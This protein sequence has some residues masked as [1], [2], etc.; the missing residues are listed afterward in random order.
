MSLLLGERSIEHVLWGLGDSLPLKIF[1]E[2]HLLII[3][4]ENI[5]EM[6]NEHFFNGDICIVAATIFIEDLCDSVLS[7]SGK[8]DVVKKKKRNSPLH[9]TTKASYIFVSSIVH[10]YKPHC[11]CKLLDL[12]DESYQY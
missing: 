10:L 8:N 3:A 9:Q 2:P 12:F 4:H 11:L 6:F 7:L 1:N 5:V